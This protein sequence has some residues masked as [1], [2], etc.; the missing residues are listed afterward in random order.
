MDDFL[1]GYLGEGLINE[2]HELF[3]ARRGGLI[4][5]VLAFEILQLDHSTDDLPGVA[6]SAGRLEGFGA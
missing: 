6:Y 1:L 3:I 2:L 5:L 4:F